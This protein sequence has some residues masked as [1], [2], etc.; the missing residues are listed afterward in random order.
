MPLTNSWISAIDDGHICFND[1]T[2]RF[3]CIYCSKTYASSYTAWKHMNDVHKD[4]FP[5][6]SEG[7]S[8]MPGALNQQRASVELGPHQPSG[9][10]QGHV[11]SRTSVIFS[12]ICGLLERGLEVH[13]T[14]DILADIV[15]MGGGNVVEE[16]PLADEATGGSEEPVAGLMNLELGSDTVYVPE[17]MIAEDLVDDSS[18]LNELENVTSTL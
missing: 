3:G 11:D 5:T 8:T 12:H 9:S 2:K 16:K 6:S 18:L 13:C 17:L 7:S 14:D 4:R 15:A 1:K 10:V